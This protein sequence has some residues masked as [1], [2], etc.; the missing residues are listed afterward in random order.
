MIPGVPASSQTKLSAVPKRHRFAVL[1]AGGVGTRFWPWSRRASPKQLLPLAEERSMLAVTAERVRSLVPDEN[2][3]IV[4]SDS[5]AKQVARDLPWLPRS[6]IL[7]EP[8]GRNTAPC[9]AWAAYEAMSRDPD[10]VLLV[11]PADHV[12]RPMAAFHKAARQAMSVAAG[13]DRLV[14]FGIEPTSPETGYGYIQEGEPIQGTPARAVKYF[15]EKPE[16]SRARRFLARGGHYWNSGMFA[17]K[18]Q[19]FLDETCRYLPELIDAMEGMESARTRGRVSAR[20]VREAYEAVE[21]VSVDVGILERSD[22]VAVLPVSF[23]WN[24][25]G[26]WDAMEALWP[27]DADGNRS[28]D[29]L[30]T[31]DASGNLV[32]TRGKPV[33]LLGVEN[34]VVVDAGDAILVCPRD[35]C[36]DVRKIVDLLDAG[37]LEKL[38]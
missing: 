2:V 7:A 18:A 1:M 15:H 20:A 34:L 22:R 17:W 32:A 16:R 14:T 11:L 3:L 6:G 24:D 23:E 37:G 21:G 13:C 29:P 33:A 8:F 5:L 31:V 38:R 19:T 26:S 9:I 12:I 25:V 4:T 27:G 36:Q 35:R 28:R 30:V 10:A